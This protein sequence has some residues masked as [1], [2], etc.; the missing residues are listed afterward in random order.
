VL[1]FP[2]TL[3]SVAFKFDGRGMLGGTDEPRPLQKT[4]LATA[5]PRAQPL[6]P[7]ILHC[8]K[9]RGV[10]RGIFDFGLG[11]PE[12]Q[13]GNHDIPASLSHK[14]VSSVPLG[15]LSFLKSPKLDP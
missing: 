5:Q 4:S 10:L 12:S 3:E 14:A 1:R 11:H 9:F 7:A 2:R 8:N 6:R 13:L 15:S